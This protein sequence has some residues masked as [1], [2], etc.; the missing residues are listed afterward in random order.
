MTVTARHVPYAVQFGAT[1]LGGITQHTVRTGTET[2][3]ETTDGSPYV[4]AQSITRQRPAASF[5]TLCPGAALALCSLVGTSIAGLAN[6]FNIYAQKLTDG[7]IRA[8]GSNHRRYRFVKGIVY[9]QSLSCEHGG[10]AKLSYGLISA[11]DG[12]N[13]P[14]Q[15]ADSVALPT[16]VTNTERYALGPFKLNGAAFGQLTSLSLNFGI[17]ANSEGADGDLWD[18]AASIGEIIPSL[19]LSATDVTWLGAAR[20]PFTGTAV[21]QA[22]TSLYLRRR[23]PDGTLVA[24]ATAQH[25]KLAP[26]GM[27]FIEDAFDASGNATGRLSLSMPLSWD[28]TNA[29]VLITLNTAIA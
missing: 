6:G 28:G 8:S 17:S 12:T 9:P 26:K 19:S 16:P 3:H 5:T 27:A 4:S 10:D 25:I 18:S 29:P 23:T 21:T 13:D 2:R 20:V 24:N 22:T 14:L 1:L 7:G 15:I 11:W